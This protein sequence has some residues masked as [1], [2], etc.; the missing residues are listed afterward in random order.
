MIPETVA[1]AEEYIKKQE[2]DGGFNE[3]VQHLQEEKEPA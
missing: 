3:M 1:S 2:A